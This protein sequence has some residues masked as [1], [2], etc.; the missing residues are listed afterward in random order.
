MTGGGVN[1]TTVT[2]GTIGI[3]DNVDAGVAGTATLV[4]ADQIYSSGG[5]LSGLNAKLTAVNGIGANNGFPVFL[6]T[7]VTN[8]EATN[9]NA[10]IAIFNTGDLTLADLGAGTAS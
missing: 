10:G 7:S 2:S 3:E 8:L 5:T 9:T 1:L 6:Q 4:S